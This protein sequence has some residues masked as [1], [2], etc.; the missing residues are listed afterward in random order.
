MSNK[1]TVGSLA[2]EVRPQGDAENVERQ[3]EMHGE[4]ELLA[5]VRENPEKINEAFRKMDF[6][7]SA[8]NLGVRHGEERLK[9]LKAALLQ[10]MS[11]DSANK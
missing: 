11:K 5:Y 6:W 2:D 9:T 4:D 1:T 10:L 7:L 8:Y 3:C